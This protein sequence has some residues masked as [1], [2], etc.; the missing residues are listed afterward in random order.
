[1]NI[2]SM[3]VLLIFDKRHKSQ[4]AIENLSLN[5]WVVIGNRNFPM[6]IFQN[7]WCISTP[8][9]AITAA[10]RHILLYYC[11]YSSRLSRKTSHYNNAKRTNKWEINER[12]WIFKRLLPIVVPL[13]YF[14][15]WDSPHF[16][17]WNYN[18]LLI[19]TILTSNCSA[20]SRHIVS[21][22]TFQLIP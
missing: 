17:F 7:G 20:Y 21:H 8:F 16:P 13:V 10:S 6:S 1:M 4:S 5:V 2:K 9:L 22:S 18:C 3:A 19:Q 15:N 14:G 12:V 11:F